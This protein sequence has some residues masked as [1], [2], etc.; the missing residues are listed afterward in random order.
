M[1]ALFAL[2]LNPALA[3]GKEKLRQGE[4]L[5]AFLDDI[6]VVA[7]YKRA[8]E[9]F[10]HGYTDYRRDYKNKNE[11]WKIEN[12]VK[13]GSAS[14][15]RTQRSSEENRGA[16][17]DEQCHNTRSRHRRLRLANRYGGVLPEVC[18]E[19]NTRRKQV[20]RAFVG[21][22]QVSWLLL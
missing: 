21:D 1:P 22:L 13:T 20:T 3:M 7:S 19:E 17:M 6:Y 8:V 18:R 12:V 16:D 4:Q 14:P 9:I 2:G 15:A 5:F 11:S 10:H